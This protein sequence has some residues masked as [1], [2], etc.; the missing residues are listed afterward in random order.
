MERELVQWLRDTLP[1]HPRLKVG[2]GDDAAVLALGDSADLVV[3]TDMLCDGTHFRVSDTPAEWIGRKC[4][5][6]NLSDLAAMAAQ[7][8]AAVVSLA[9]PRNHPDKLGLAQGLYKGMLPLA[10]EFGLT[11]AGGDTN[12]WDGPLCVSVTAMGGA[13]PPGSLLRSGAEPGDWILVTGELGGSLGGGHLDF[14]PR[15]REALLLNERYDLHA[16]MDISDG[17]GLDLSRMCEASG[18][19]A[20]VYREN[21]PASPAAE[22]LAAAEGGEA[23]DHALA[24]GEDFELLLAAPP[25]SAERMLSDQPLECGLTHVGQVTAERTLRLET[26]DGQT[27]SWTPRGYEHD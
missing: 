1:A 21:V 20:I 7:P 26:R 18:V 10:E 11:I 6:A 22:Q 12:A 13:P 27:L 4:L 15:V 24:D 25:A 19:G 8:T 3:T 14:T 9:L 2:L 23:V 5:A 16:G 17:L